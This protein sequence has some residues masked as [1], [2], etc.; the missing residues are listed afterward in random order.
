MSLKRHSSVVFVG[1]DSLDDIRNN[2][3]TELFISGGCIISDELV[4]SPDVITHGGSQ[5]QS[6]TAQILV[7]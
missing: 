5:I 7:F 1:V 6:K 4:L 2:S 3:C